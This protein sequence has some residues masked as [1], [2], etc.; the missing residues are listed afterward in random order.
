VYK[1]GQEEDALYHCDDCGALWTEMTKRRLVREGEWHQVGT[2]I[3]TQKDGTPIRLATPFKCFNV[4]AG[5]T[6]AREKIG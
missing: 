4:D 3:G 5:V 1:K 2:V 6:P